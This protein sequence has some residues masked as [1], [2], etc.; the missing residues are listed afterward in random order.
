MIRFMRIYITA[1]SL[2][3]TN[4]VLLAIVGHV[5]KYL[6]YTRHENK[7]ATFLMEI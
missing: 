4:A 6:T 7:I 3:L 2:V 1:S 5:Q